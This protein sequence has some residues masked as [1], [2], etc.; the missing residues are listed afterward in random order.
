M[1][2][3]IKIVF[4]GTPAFVVS[5]LESLDKHFNL[6]GVVTSPDKIVGRHQT[7]TP[8]PVKS[9]SHGK[10]VLT[11][12]KLNQSFIAELSNLQP[13][14][15]IVASYGKIIPQSIL[16]VPKYG[17]LNVHPSLLPKYRGATPI[18][19]AIL[20]G[21][22]I[23]GISV[24]KMDDKMDHGPLIYLEEIELSDQDTFETLS[25]KMF[26]QA[27]EILIKLIPEYISGKASLTEQ[28]HSQ[29]SFCKLLKKE[30][31]FFDI[32]S[33]PSPQVLDR[34]IRAY[35]PWPNAW[36]NWNG[37]VVKFYPNQ[38]IQMEGKKPTGLNDFLRGYPTFPISI[39]KF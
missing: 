19:T 6:V 25:Y 11:P 13:D 2:K 4:F 24:I 5:I 21:D 31:G 37:K 16:N 27:G 34:I 14:L 17:A 22:P 28:D 3:Q 15:I 30:D 26:Q 32:Q 1:D 39:F 7:W 18:Q 36:T 9:A 12:D 20:N 8:S 23:S 35:Y 29:A 38:I 33:P 10:K